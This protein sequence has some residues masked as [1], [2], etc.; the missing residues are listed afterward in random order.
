[1]TKN[2]PVNHET[3]VSPKDQPHFFGHCDPTIARA[4]VVPATSLDKE[5]G[6]RYI[7]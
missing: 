7:L 6:Q 2:R 1:M 5:G 4:M 3:T